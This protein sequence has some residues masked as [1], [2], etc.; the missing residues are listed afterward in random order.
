MNVW[1]RFIT[2]GV[3]LAMVLNLLFVFVYVKKRVGAMRYGSYCLW[4]FMMLLVFVFW[5][6]A[7]GFTIASVG[8]NDSIGLIQ[9]VFSAQNL[10]G[11]RKV[12]TNPTITNM[13]NACVNAGGDLGGRVLNMNNNANELTKLYSFANEL[14]SLR[15]NAR[16]KS[17][18]LETIQDKLL[19][20]R[21]DMT[22]VNQDP[23]NESLTQLNRYSNIYVNQTYQV[24]CSIS[25][26]DFWVIN[27]SD[28]NSIPENSQCQV[29]LEY[30][31]TSFSSRYSSKPKDCNFNST[32]F[33]S[34]QSALLAYH[35]SLTKFLDSNLN[36]ISQLNLDY[37][38]LSE[39]YSHMG[40]TL[41]KNLDM[42][43]PIL[44]HLK[45]IF[46][47]LA[48]GGPLFEFLNCCKYFNV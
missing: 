32:D 35:D 36:I 11:Q 26:N 21:T 4:W 13:I 31:L 37:T 2:F 45:V 47:P 25:S 10:Q 48:N 17:N 3:I 39:E 19:K 20:A 1:L 16:N 42:L 29:L 8:L 12:I 5:L 28:C 14:E 9:Y 7:A 34:I 23:L 24:E 43:V 18:E 38:E 6:L 40:N 33:P 30:D 44:S 41:I 22:L 46:D 27:T 15:G